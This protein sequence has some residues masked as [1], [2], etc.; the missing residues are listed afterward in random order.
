MHCIVLLT[1]LSGLLENCAAT[2]VLAFLCW[3]IYRVS[4][5]RCGCIVELISR[6]KLVFCDDHEKF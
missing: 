3:K 5:C 1:F 6:V 4:V 2:S